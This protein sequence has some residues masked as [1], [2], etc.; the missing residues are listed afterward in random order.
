MLHLA[1]SLK[2]VASSLRRIQCI[3]KC[4]QIFSQMCL[5]SK[6][7]CTPGGHTQC[8]EHHGAAFGIHLSSNNTLVIF[9]QEV[10][11]CN[12]FVDLIRATLLQIL[13]K[14]AQR[15]RATNI[16]ESSCTGSWSNPGHC[17]QCTA[18]SIECVGQENMTTQELC[19]VPFEELS[20]EVFVP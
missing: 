5:L 11:C 6:S 4:F 17:R 14:L 18:A 16:K 12:Y 9:I 10:L 2:S 15:Q 7:N 19:Q 20:Q 13:W 3:V 1:M 8:H